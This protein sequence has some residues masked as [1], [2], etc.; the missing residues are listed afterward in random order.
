MGIEF[1]NYQ[2]ARRISFLSVG[3]T[4]TFEGRNYILTDRQSQLGEPPSCYVVD[5]CTGLLRALQRD[6]LVRMI[7]ITAKVEPDAS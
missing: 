4:F 6:A 5:L 7:K 1:V 2:N 3:A